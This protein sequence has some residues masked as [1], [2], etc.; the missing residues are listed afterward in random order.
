MNDYSYLTVSSTIN[1]F[2]KKCEFS[3]YIHRKFKRLAK[4]PI[5][6]RGRGSNMSNVLTQSAT[7]EY[8]AL[9]FDWYQTSTYKNSKICAH[10]C[11][12]IYI[13]EKITDCL[14][15]CHVF[16]ACGAL[17]ASI[18]AGI[19]IPSSWMSIYINLLQRTCGKETFKEPILKRK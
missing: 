10:T 16:F 19:V 12:S 13:S 9:S 2:K 1:A 11:T 17:A 8:T 18:C 5:R 4:A 7:T 3:L 14:I 6:L 15:Y